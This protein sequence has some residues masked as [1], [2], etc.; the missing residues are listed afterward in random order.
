MT[1]TST[2]SIPGMERGMARRV[3]G[4]AASS[5]R[6]GIWTISFKPEER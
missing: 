4:S 6:H 1:S 2:V 5:L 3:S